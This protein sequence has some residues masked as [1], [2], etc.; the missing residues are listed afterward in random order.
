MKYL[1]KAAVRV[2]DAQNKRMAS[3][4]SVASVVDEKD[5]HPDSLA[6][7]L[8]AKCIEPIVADVTS[9]EDESE[10]TPANPL[11]T[12]YHPVPGNAEGAAPYEGPMIVN[13][14]YD[15]AGLAALSAETLLVMVGENKHTNENTV[16]TIAA[17]K[18]P[19]ES[20]ISFLTA[21]HAPQAAFIASCDEL[22][23][24][25]AEAVSEEEDASSAAPSSEDMLGKTAAESVEE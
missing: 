11:R 5:I 14:G 22:V 25:A 20:A 15:A 8:A 18:D 13:D 2:R 12:A 16:D 3:P 6:G 9:G 17:M 23:A 21:D 1:V 10:G 19:K 7:A 24:E 4:L